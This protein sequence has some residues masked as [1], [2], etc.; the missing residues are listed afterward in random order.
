MKKYISVLTVV[1]I[2]FFKP[3]TGFAQCPNNC[4]DGR[5]E[6]CDICYLD[7]IDHVYKCLRIQN[8]V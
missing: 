5:P 3:S 6:T 1:F 2:H 4:D 8:M 7:S